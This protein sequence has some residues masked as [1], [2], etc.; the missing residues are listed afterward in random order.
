MAQFD[1]RINPSRLTSETFPYLVEVQSD[2]LNMVRRRIV[3]PLARKDA[4][5][6]IFPTLNPTF[7]IRGESVV[8][9]P[10]DI[11]S[12]SESALGEVIGSL[13]S[14]SDLII[15]ALDLLLARY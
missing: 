5:D 8:L 1:V 4:P 13:K 2:S 3:V 12:I 9:I 11:A 6:H 10:L 15:G 14:E 7:Q